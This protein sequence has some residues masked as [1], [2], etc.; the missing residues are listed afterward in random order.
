[1]RSRILHNGSGGGRGLVL[2]ETPFRFYDFGT[3]L[4]HG[5]SDDYWTPRVRH[6]ADSVSRAT[7]CA[8]GPRYPSPLRDRG[9]PKSAILFLF[10]FFS[11]CFLSSRRGKQSRERGYP[12][13]PPPAWESGD[14]LP[15]PG[16][17][18]LDRSVMGGIEPI[19]PR[20]CQD[21]QI[22]PAAEPVSLQHLALA[23]DGWRGGGRGSGLFT[24]HGVM[25]FCF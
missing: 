2:T 23:R 3:H 4:S 6:R 8:D 5:S 11:S 9:R 10:F 17:F 19:G 14:C 13:P 20:A 1:M 21:T 24:I 16:P 15:C 22:Q 25:A 7:T 12:P 18:P